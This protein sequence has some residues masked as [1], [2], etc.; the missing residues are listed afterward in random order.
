MLRKEK[1]QKR[2]TRPIYHNKASFGKPWPATVFI[3]AGSE[4]HTPT[5]RARSTRFFPRRRRR[6]LAILS[7]ASSPRHGR[8]LLAA[9]VAVASVC[10]GAAAAA[11]AG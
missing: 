9:L 7:L 2:E 1:K 3:W 10:L 4:S 11:Q 8:L 5:G 6:L